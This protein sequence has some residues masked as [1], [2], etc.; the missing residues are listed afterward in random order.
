MGHYTYFALEVDGKESP[1]HEKNICDC[2]NDGYSVF[3]DSA[4]WYEHKEDMGEY[5]KKYPKQLFK[6]KGT[7]MEG[8][9]DVWYTYFKN[10]K[11]WST[12]GKLIFEEF[13]EKYLE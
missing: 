5:S 9:V 7:G 11:S 6:L 10:G 3:E 13:R 4:K 1:E 2:Y 12:Y 8:E